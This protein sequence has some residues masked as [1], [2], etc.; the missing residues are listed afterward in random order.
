MRGSCGAEELRCER[1]AARGNC[2][3]R[4]LRFEVIMDSWCGGGAA[5]GG[6]GAG[7][8]QC[9]AVLLWGGN[10]F[11]RGYCGYQV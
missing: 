8:L 4:E 11:C 3:V 2:S 5:R 1:V 7:G 6:R 10:A 9:K